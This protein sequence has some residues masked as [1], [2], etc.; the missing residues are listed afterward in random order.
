M[1]TK[2][3]HKKIKKYRDVVIPLD[4]NTK[5]TYLRFA[6]EYIIQCMDVSKNIIIRE[7]IAIVKE[8]IKYNFI[9]KFNDRIRIKRNNKLFKNILNAILEGENVTISK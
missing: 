3:T 7:G 1:Y 8:N 4:N 2:E 5:H 9:K 6:S